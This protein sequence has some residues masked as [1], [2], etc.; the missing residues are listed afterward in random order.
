M[1]NKKFKKIKYKEIDNWTYYIRL[2]QNRKK[3]A[4]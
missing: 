2:I 4:K 3:Q 1:I